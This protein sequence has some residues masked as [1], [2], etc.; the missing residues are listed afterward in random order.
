MLGAN[1]ITSFSDGTVESDVCDTLYEGEYENQ[2]SLHPWKFATL[3]YDL[4]VRTATIPGQKF[5]Y[6]WNLPGELLTL[7]GVY[8]DN[9]PQKDYE[10]TGQ[11]IQA[12]FSEDAEPYIW[13][14]FSVE[15]NR[16]PPF[17]VQGMV[18]SLA[19]LFAGPITEKDSK[20]KV[21]TDLAA[22][23]MAKARNKDS[24][25]SPPRKVD[26]NLFLSYR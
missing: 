1:K 10:R 18:M 11:T 22:L 17:F 19:A 4:G 8:L 21:Y 9:N 6:S 7:R 20:I 3:W 15:E 13:G 24:Q 26:T 23:Q 5:D 16:L 12:N 25:E 14:M 2:L